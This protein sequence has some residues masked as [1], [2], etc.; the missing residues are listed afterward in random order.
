MRLYVA[1]SLLLIAALGCS[2]SQPAAPA[3]DIAKEEAA[4][5]AADAQW[6]AAAKAHDLEKT[7]NAWADDATIF[8][9]DQPVPIRGRQ[10]IHDYVAQAFATPGFAIEWTTDQVVVSKSGDMAYS[11]GSD[12]F[13]FPGPNKKL[14]KQKTGGVVVWRK[15]PDG[16]WKA[17]IDISTMQGPPSAQ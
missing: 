15:Q 13:T 4:I 5:R 17:V 8:A 3:V 6:L 7:V 9:S 11:T 16:A 12:V 1:T 14:V 2:T 10:A